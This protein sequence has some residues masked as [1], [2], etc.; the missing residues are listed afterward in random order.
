MTLIGLGDDR[1]NKVLRDQ[2]R[3]KNMDIKREAAR[4]MASLPP[5]RIAAIRGLKKDQRD[6]VK[7]LIEDLYRDGSM[8]Q[9]F[10]MIASLEDHP[11]VQERLTA[12]LQDP[13]PV[14]IL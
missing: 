10:D 6:P 14:L 11:V 12:G 8:F 2:I 13:H 3:S 4:L 1:G 9:N 5:E 7:I